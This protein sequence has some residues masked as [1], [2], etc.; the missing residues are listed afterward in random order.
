ME[1]HLANCNNIDS[2]MIEIHENHLNIKYAIN[3]TGKS[4]IASAIQHWVNDRERGTEDIKKLLPFKHQNM[5]DHNPEI[6][7]LERISS[8]RIFNEDYINDF[9]FQPDELL[10]ASFDV[11]IRDQNYENGMEEIETHINLLRQLLDEDKD[12]DDL[13]KDLSELSNS[14]GRPVRKGV[15]GSSKIAKAFKSG[16]KVQNIPEGLEDY[17][18]FIQ[19]ENNYRWIKWQ[20]DGKTYVE[21]SDNCPYCTSD[22]RTKKVKIERVS[23]VYDPRAIEHLNSVILVFQRL[24]KYFSPDTKAKIDEFITNIDGYSD[25]QINYLLEIRDEI[26]RLNKKF[27]DAQNLSFFSLKD[28]DKIIEGLKT[29]IIDVSLFPHLNSENTRVKA[30]IVNEKVNELLTKAGELQGCIAKQKI[31]IEKLIE[32]NRNEINGFLKNA[33]YRYAVDLIE[34]SNGQHRL[35]L[36]DNEL[37]QQVGQARQHLSFGE[38]NAFALVLFMYDAV[39]SSPDLIILDDP[40][41]SFDKNK[42]YAI[43]DMLF[44]K[45]KAFRGKTVIMLTH[46]LEPLIDMLQHHRDRF[47]IPR[48]AF[49]ENN[50]GRLTEKV[51]SQSDI[52]NFLEIIEENIQSDTLNI[53]NRLVYLRRL[54]EVT[55][56]K[57]NGYHVLSNLFH[58]REVL[59]KPIEDGTMVEMSDEDI[60]RGCSDIQGK[61][62]EFN[63]AILL[64]TVSNDIAMKGLYHSSGN[65]YEKL[66]IYRMLFDDKT[67]GVGSTIIQ[68]FINEAFHLENNYI[69]QLSPS[70]YQL[71]PQYVIDECDNIISSIG[72]EQN[73]AH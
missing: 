68:K 35:K 29:Y 59:R 28:V 26:D 22:I 71:V 53:I 39:K 5:G 33:G 6:R 34:D 62:P 57:S 32:E 1:I 42:K 18:E 55:N 44:S 65:N 21:S 7:G 45:E 37:N 13:V 25:D 66:H 20:Q 36:F 64:A 2:G 58:K 15:H 38:R 43:I 30:S 48:S 11:F 47:E 69:Y 50:Q 46:D 67:D 61:I 51:I 60:R 14:F 40:I 3:G 56:N 49:L 52:K 63:Y 9:V 31:Y 23:E 72:G 4:T 16:N 8:I 27:L 70:K 19:S 17:K 10:K 24:N 54:Y 41:S 73:Y 12:I